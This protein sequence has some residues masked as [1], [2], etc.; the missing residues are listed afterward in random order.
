MPAREH[1]LFGTITLQDLAFC[2]MPVAAVLV[3]ILSIL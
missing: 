2:A 1:R 3:S